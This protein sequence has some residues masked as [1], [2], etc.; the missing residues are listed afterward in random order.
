VVLEVGFNDAIAVVILRLE[1]DL[2]ELSDSA[3]QQVRERVSSAEGASGRIGTTASLDCR[4]VAGIKREDALDVG[5]VL[6]VLLRECRVEAKLKRVV[7]NDFCEVV[8]IGV[9]RVCFVPWEV[10][11]VRR[12]TAAVCGVVAERNGRKLAALTV[13]KEH[14]HAAGIAGCSA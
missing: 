2:G 5:R 9:D 7:T 6:L 13:C 4:R 14:A 12:E 8:T 11:G 3:D 1:V 10:A